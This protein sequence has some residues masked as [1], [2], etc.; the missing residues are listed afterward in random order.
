MARLA[1]GELLAGRLRQGRRRGC[2]DPGGRRE[3]NTGLRKDF[4]VPTPSLWYAKPD[5]TGS[6]FSIGSGQFE[7]HSPPA[8]RVTIQTPGG[9]LWLWPYEYVVCS[10]PMAL[11][12]DPDCTIHTLG[13][14]APVDEEQM[15]YLM[16]R[17]WSY[18]DAVLALLDGLD[19]SEWGWVEFPEYARAA[20]EGV[21]QRPRFEERKRA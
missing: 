10:D 5:P 7:V 17:G 18:D 2:L 19:A 13:G 4:R 15:F 20:F 3:P 14:R 21:G 8:Y 12:A 6:R 11:I 16:S 1:G 9:T